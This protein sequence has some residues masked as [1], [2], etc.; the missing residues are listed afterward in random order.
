M[1]EPEP[2]GSPHARRAPSRALS[3]PAGS[4]WTTFA[5][6]FACVRS[7]SVRIAPRVGELTVSARMRIDFRSA[8]AEKNTEATM[9]L[10]TTAEGYVKALKA[11]RASLVFR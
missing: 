2:A 9:A 7:N 5:F 4:H 1:K 3:R 10:Q 11:W 8:V 6:R